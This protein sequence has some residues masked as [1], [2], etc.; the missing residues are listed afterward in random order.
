[1]ENP[2]IIL[3]KHYI[4]LFVDELLSIKKTYSAKQIN[5]ARIKLLYLH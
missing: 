4:T 5:Q 1:M 3:T 2:H